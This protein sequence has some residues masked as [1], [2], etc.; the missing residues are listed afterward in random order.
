[1]GAATASALSSIRTTV[2]RAGTLAPTNI[3]GADSGTGEKL[4]HFIL[5]DLEPDAP[6]R[7][8]YLTG[9]KNRDVLPGVLRDGGVA[10]ESLQVYATQGSSAFA[11]DLEG[12]I[13]SVPSGERV[14]R[15]ATSRSVNMSCAERKD[16]DW[17]I[18]F[19]APS[20]AEFVTPTLRKHFAIPDMNAQTFSAKIAAI[21]PTT[22]TFLHDKLNMRVDVLSPKPSPEALAA[23]IQGFDVQR[24]A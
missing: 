10:L 18:V 20:A 16:R 14:S 2:P 12:A 5:D 15:F 4:A 6:R 21:G 17:W 7:L 3:R 23:A 24:N 8:L 22:S 9:D 19:F 13:N 1:M 11:A